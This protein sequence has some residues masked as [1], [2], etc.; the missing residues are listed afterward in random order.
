MT[1]D[2]WL[3]L[4]KIIG[5]PAVLAGIYRLWRDMRTDRRQ[6]LDDARADALNQA[7]LEAVA[8]EANAALEAKNAELNATKAEVADVKAQLADCLASKGQPL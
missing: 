6:E 7:R 4:L 2:G 5:G 3:D 1:G 8:R